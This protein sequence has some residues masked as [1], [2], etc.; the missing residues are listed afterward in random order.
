MDDPSF[1]PGKPPPSR[2]GCKIK[3]NFFANFYAKFYSVDYKTSR[4]VLV[5]IRGHIN[6]V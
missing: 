2:L 6:H 1:F 5:A 4:Y 3:P